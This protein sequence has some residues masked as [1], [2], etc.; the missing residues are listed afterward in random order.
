MVESGQASPKRTVGTLNVGNLL[1]FFW[2][3]LKAEW[4]G[5]TYLFL[6]SINAVFDF[7]EFLIVFDEAVYVPD[8]LFVLC[9]A[10]F[11]IC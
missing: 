10:P 6:R 11:P 3:I 9:F 1:P 4:G 7:V 5:Y 2:Q 8:N